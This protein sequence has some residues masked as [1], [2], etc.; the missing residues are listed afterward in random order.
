[1]R[2]VSEEQT[3]FFCN[4]HIS[5]YTTCLH[6]Y[7]IASSPQY[8]NLSDDTELYSENETLF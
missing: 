2:N 8:Q 3:V 7:I 5:F 6:V 4:L 1:M